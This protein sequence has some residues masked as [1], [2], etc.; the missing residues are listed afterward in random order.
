MHAS[1]PL[2]VYNGLSL[3]GDL[4][5]APEDASTITAHA[6]TVTQSLQSAAGQTIESSSRSST[7]TA[8]LQTFLTTIQPVLD[9]HI[10]DFR[11]G[12]IAAHIHMTAAIRTLTLLGN[13][14][15]AVRACHTMC[16][17]CTATADELTT[18]LCAPCLGK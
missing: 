18:R 6:N 5:L 7:L 2:I 11:V 4:V 13:G 1:D 10:D 9:R 15:E 16:V 8:A 3:L 12:S 17:V 14:A